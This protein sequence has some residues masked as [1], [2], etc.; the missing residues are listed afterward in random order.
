M[1]AF[2]C[3]SCHPWA[4]LEGLGPEEASSEGPLIGLRG[5]LAWMLGTRRL[6]LRP[7]ASCPSMTVECAAISR[8]PSRWVLKWRAGTYSLCLLRPEA[9]RTAPKALRKI[10]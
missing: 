8:A 7:C 9:R 6:G 5:T 1:A 10:P 4:S 3:S 2:L